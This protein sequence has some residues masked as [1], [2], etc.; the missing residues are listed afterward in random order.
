M[1]NFALKSHRFRGSF[2]TSLFV[3][4]CCL[5]LVNICNAEAN[6]TDN[7]GWRLDYFIVN[8][9][10][11]FKIIESDMVDRFEYNSSDHIPIKFVFKINK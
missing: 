4:V 5:G 9:S 3:V 11:K 7:K 1:K 2:A 6:K 10:N 8:S